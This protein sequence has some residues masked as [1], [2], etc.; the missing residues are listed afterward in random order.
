MRKDTEQHTSEAEKLF[1]RADQAEEQGRVEEAVEL[2]LRAATL[3][4]TGAQINLGNQ[5]SQGR[6][7]PKSDSKAAYWY[8]RAYKN[9]EESGALNLAIDKLKKGNSRS[10]IFW[11]KRA[12]E[13][14]S[15]EAAVE[16]ARIYLRNRRSK[17]KAIELL[18]LAQKMKRS[19]I[20]E[21]AKEDAGALLASIARTR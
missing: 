9:G 10:A 13:M 7:V 12:V 19:E 18:N 16:L 4:H 8:K 1:I 3:E 20:S 17:T 11:L 5:Y 15:G 21:Q 2:L 6:G 14:H